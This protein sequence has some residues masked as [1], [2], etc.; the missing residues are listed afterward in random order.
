MTEADVS[1][2]LRKSLSRFGAVA[3]KASDRFHA[4]RPDVL[5]CFIG[6]FIA[7]E[8]KIHP[9]QPTAMQKYTLLELAYAGAD[10]YVASYKKH[11]KELTL[12][13]I[14][15]ETDGFESQD[16]DEVAKWVLRLPY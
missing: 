16:F 4:S 5:V 9:N 10:V 7:I 12:Y 8:T 6:R 3:W 15:V 13:P 1:T 14:G 11:T 2:K